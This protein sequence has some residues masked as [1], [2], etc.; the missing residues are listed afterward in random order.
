LHAQRALVHVVGNRVRAAEILGISR[1]YL[2]EL[3]KVIRKINRIRIPGRKIQSSLHRK[4]AE[5][6]DGANNCRRSGRI[7]RMTEV[8]YEK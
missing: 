3:F 7:C 5:I 4:L 8:E 2:D 1:T 6:P